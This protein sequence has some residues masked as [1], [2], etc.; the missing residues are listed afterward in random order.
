MLTI[1]H[2]SDIAASRKYFLEEKEKFSSAEF[3]K[4]SQINLTD[5]SQLL[6][7]GGLFENSHTIF[8]EQFLTDRKK[9]TEKD[10]IISYLTKQAKSNAIFLW[11][12]KELDRTALSQFKEASI[13]SYK[14][15]STLFTLLDAIKPKNGTQ[16]VQLF[17]RSLE[18]SDAEMVFFM[19]VRQLRILL[20]LS[21][22]NSETI[23]EVSR[24]AP[25]QKGKLERQVSLFEKNY[26]EKLYSKLFQI[27][28]AQK[29]GTLS[30]SLTSTIDFF[31]IEL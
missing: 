1:I 15:S 4:G 16:L 22:K 7:G 23:T 30:S 11:E 25:W 19:L 17:H 14:L 10:A 3:L 24:L 27:E 29:T 13:K 26:L 5:L 8:I 12:G 31:L 21:D 9:S 18:T 20:A 6:E 28:L 2:G